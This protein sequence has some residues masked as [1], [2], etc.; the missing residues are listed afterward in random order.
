[1]QSASD[2]KTVRVSIFNQTYTLASTGEPGEIEALAHAVDELMT[3][4]AQRAGNI[5][6]QRVAVLACMHM[7]DQLRSVERELVG[8]RKRVDEKSREFADLLDSHL[9]HADALHAGLPEAELLDPA[10][11]NGTVNAEIADDPPLEDDLTGHAAGA[12]P[13]A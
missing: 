3:D 10:S 13:V 6:G 1:M 12:E 7:A 4:I 5:D 9:L 8:L 2:R 11:L